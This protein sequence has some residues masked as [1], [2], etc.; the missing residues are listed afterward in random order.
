M[1]VTHAHRDHL[2]R[3]SLA[4][5][6]GAAPVVVPPH[7]ERLV[8]RVGLLAVE[9]LEPGRS[10]R[11]RT[12]RSRR[13]RCA[14]R[15]RAGSATTRAAAPAATSCARRATSIYVAGDT[16]YFSGF[17]EIGRRFQ[18]DVAL[19]PISGYEPAGFRDE[20]LSPLDAVYAFEDLGARVLVPT[21]YGSFPLSY[22]PL[23]APLPGC[24]RS[25]APAAS[26]PVR[27]ATPDGRRSTAPA[28]PSWIT[29]RASTFG[30]QGA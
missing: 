3:A 11:T 18:P 2:S 30:K 21:S 12:S 15:A 9:E 23:D 29:A 7:C 6:P 22:E 14:T 5:F 24:A 25:C 4:R 16:G 1:L 26:P 10:Y 19:L 20:H 28:S 8:R 13:C 27:R 17:V